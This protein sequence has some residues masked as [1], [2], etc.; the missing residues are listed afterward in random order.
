M[1]DID[2]DELDR[3]VSSLMGTVPQDENKDD[4]GDSVTVHQKPAF[5]SVEEP[6]TSMQP[7]SEDNTPP[8]TQEESAIVPVTES[9]PAEEKAPESAVSRAS[10]QVSSPPSRGRF[11]DVVRPSRDMHK[12]L[13]PTSRQGV[14]LQPSDSRRSLGQSASEASED[15]SNDVEARLTATQAVVP[16]EKEDTA[17]TAALNRP[18]FEASPMPLQAESEETDDTSPLSSPFLPDAK[19]EK[20]PLGRPVEASLTQGQDAEDIVQNITEAAPSGEQT[21]FADT[22]AQRPEQPV[23]AELDSTL[24]RIETST[25]AVESSEPVGD[26]NM[27]A[28][29]VPTTEASVATPISAATSS[30]PAQAQRTMAATSIPQQYKLEAT[31]TQDAPASA[32][33]DTQ[34]LAHPA[35]SRPGWVFILA[36]IGILVLGALGGAAVYYLGLI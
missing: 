4:T 23:P 27:T 12:P 26:G 3:A 33:Y 8:T 5:A 21:I 10:R 32:I 31:P 6:A 28:A 20:R 16:D 13:S 7:K 35:K 14:T 29:P 1:K 24:L 11:M 19:V 22:D 18:V 9:A 15:S 30:L 34:P 25:A 36:I 2:F 17:S